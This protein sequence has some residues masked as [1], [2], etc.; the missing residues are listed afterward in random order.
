MHSIDCLPPRDRL[1]NELGTF[2]FQS[3]CTR[4]SCQAH[5]QLAVCT[6]EF[7]HACIRAQGANGRQWSLCGNALSILLVHAHGIPDISSN[8]KLAKT[9]LSRD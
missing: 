8:R 1:C 3:K 9:S 4:E 6:W 5:L 2:R 7:L